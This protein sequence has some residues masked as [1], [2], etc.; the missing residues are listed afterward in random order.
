MQ[1]NR[2]RVSSWSLRSKQTAECQTAVPAQVCWPSLVGILSCWP[3]SADISISQPLAVNRPDSFLLDDDSLLTRLTDTYKVNFIRSVFF[4]SS[5]LPRGKGFVSVQYSEP[6]LLL[7]LPW[8]HCFTILPGVLSFKNSNCVLT[9]YVFLFVIT[10]D[11]GPC[12]SLRFQAALSTFFFSLFYFPLHAVGYDFGIHL[13][14]ADVFFNTV[15][16]LGS[17][18]LS[19]SIQGLAVNTCWWI[20]TASFYE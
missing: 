15:S 2:Y 14:S 11:S 4:P 8:F 3:T 13:S 7:L 10:E 12:C 9:G 17:K 6:L 20:P 5:S 18:W 1:S 19:R 16:L